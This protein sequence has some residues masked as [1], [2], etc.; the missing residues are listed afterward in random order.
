MAYSGN[1]PQATCVLPFTQLASHQGQPS[2]DGVP[3]QED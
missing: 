1:I 2:G 3:G